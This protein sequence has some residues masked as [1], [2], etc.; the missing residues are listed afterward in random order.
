[1]VYGDLADS[2]L[3]EALGEGCRRRRTPQGTNTGAFTLRI[4]FG[5]GEGGGDFT[6]PGTMRK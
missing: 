5:F 3:T 1:M 2:L 4:G 6:Y